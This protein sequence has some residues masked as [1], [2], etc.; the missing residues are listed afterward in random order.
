MR[1][2][3]IVCAVFVFMTM[4]CIASSQDELVDSGVISADTAAK[5]DGGKGGNEGAS[6]G[7]SSKPEDDDTAAEFLRS[8]FAGGATQDEQ[9][10]TLDKR[11]MNNHNYLGKRAMNNQNY[12]GKRAMNNQNYLG[13]R[14]MNNHNYLGKRAMNNQNYL[15]K[16]AMNNHNY[17]GKR[18]MNNQNYLGKR[19]T[20]NDNVLGDKIDDSETIQ[21]VP[22]LPYLCYIDD[23]GIVL[24]CMPKNEPTAIGDDVSK[25]DNFVPIEETD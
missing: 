9:D 24:S 22:I 12:L 3:I 8:M 2:S 1:G 4:T 15:G 5:E 23:A 10:D 17:L 25:D 13:K 20:T 6:E 18:A 19:A 14:A 16:R 7:A 11:A 21:F